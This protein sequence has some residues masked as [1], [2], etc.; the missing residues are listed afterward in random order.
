MEPRGMP[1]L[2]LRY[3]GE[4]IGWIN[5]ACAFHAADNDAVYLNAAMVRRYLA[6]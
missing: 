1:V 4:V 3:L 2:E 5:S 6:A